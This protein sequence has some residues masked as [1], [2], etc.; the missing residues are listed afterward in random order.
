MSWICYILRST[1]DKCTRTYNGSTN[2]LERRIRQHNGELKG[3][4]KATKSNRPWEPICII[5]NIPDQIT[6]LKLE[7]R[8]KHPTGHRKRPNCY[9]RPRGRIRGLNDFIASDIW[10]ETYAKYDLKCMIVKDM[11]RYLMMFPIKNLKIV[12]KINST[13]LS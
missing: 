13:N 3:G 11:S 6:A 12:D 4:A 10:S 9:C 2:N 7:W 1:N 8:I 5:Y